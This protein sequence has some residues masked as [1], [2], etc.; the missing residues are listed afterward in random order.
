[1]LHKRLLYSADMRGWRGFD[2][3]KGVWTLVYVSRHNWHNFA[4][5]YKNC[6]LL[7]KDSC[8]IKSYIC[9]SYTSIEWQYV[10]TFVWF[11]K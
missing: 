9:Q 10:G 7:E 1:M 11:L 6:Q 3:G 2:N 5:I 8:D 4:G